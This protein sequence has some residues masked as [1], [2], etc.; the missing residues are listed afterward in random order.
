MSCGA[1]L[2]TELRPD[3]RRPVTVLF[4]DVAG[5]TVL[6]ERFEPET[7]RRIMSRYFATVGEACE[8]H[9]GTVEK[10]IGDAAMVVFG[11]PVAQEDHALRAVRAAAELGTALSR[12]NG[13]LDREW[14]VRI[15]TRTGINSGEVVAGDPASGQALVTGEAV[16]VAA[17]L[18]QAAE[19]G[20]VLIG[21]ATH[22]LVSAVIRAEPA[23]PVHINGR[24]EPVETFRLVEVVSTA[25]QPA[26]RL[27]VRMLGRDRELTLLSEEFER[28]LAK[29]SARRAVVLGPAGIG[30]S[31]LAQEL[32]ATIGEQASVFSGSCLPYGEGI[33]FWPLAEIVRQAAGEHPETEIARLLVGDP[34]AESIAEEVMQAVG[35]SEGGGS[36]RDASWAVRRFLEALARERPV[37]LVID[38]V[39]WAE[40]PLLDLI[41]YLTER[42][43]APL[44]LVCLAREELTE[45]RPAWVGGE[46]E[47]GAIVLQPLP[48]AE[49]RTLVDDLVAQDAIDDS[50]RS[51]LVDR[52]DGNPLFAEQMLAFVREGDG[53]EQVAIPPTIHAL[54]AARLDRLPVAELEV[55]GAASVIGREFW[56]DAVSALVGA[57]DGVHGR[58]SSLTSREL[59]ASGASTLTGDEGFAFRHALIRDAAYEALTKRK[60][61]A[62][63]ERFANWLEDRYGERLVELEAILGYHL[64]QAYRYH[65]E[66]APIDESARALARRGAARL[67]SAGRRAARARQD[68]AAV[69]LLERGSALLPETDP[70]RLELLP[71]IGESL[72]GTANHERAGEI[73]EQ[74]LELARQAGNSAVEGNSRLGRAHIWFVAEPERSPDEIVHEAEQAIEILEQVGDG[75]GLGEAWRLIGEMR[76]Y[77]GQAAAGQSALERALEYLGPEVSPRSWNAILFA[78]GMCLLD[79]P[80]HLDRAVEFARERL[81]VAR[82]EGIPSLEA[83]ML[84]LLGIG[85]T[86]LGQFAPARESLAASTEISDELGLTYMAQW[87]KRSLGHLELAAGNPLAAEQAVRSSYEVLDEMGLKGSLGEAAIPL[88]DALRLQGRVDEAEGFLD[89]VKE[90]WASNDASI[91]APR[92]AVRAKLLAAR[93]WHVHAERAAAR[94][95]R[96]VRRTDWSCLQADA[97]IAHAEVLELAGREAETVPVLR[98][99][100]RVAGEKGYAVVAAAAA[101]GL[102]RLGEEAADQVR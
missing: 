9:G 53:R 32:R 17:R 52:A 2:G 5:S 92:L 54:L 16:N 23:A 45:Q 27:D 87:S 47:A 65:A 90:D 84:H 78:L 76:T 10:F 18:E 67:A 31:R 77:A 91:E 86:R 13:E 36:G 81:T 12:L 62:L 50:V 49:M 37:A 6:A 3:S 63:H 83:D 11:I 25:G 58:L 101:E 46:S 60:R 33:T 79:G 8:R 42:V 99:A 14:G 19:P 26:R 24:D 59:V 1:R 55:I 43:D 56:A 93:G 4:N 44:M 7:L 72:E 68:G 66:L 38:D 20:D 95:L 73:Y 29:R 94:A 74:A 96:L 28:V 64:E 82:E 61:G 22:R 102:E 15:E 88:A 48:E 70:E 40:P 30:K 75:R 97:L 57:P 80:T 71:A 21:E 85:E 98:E 41:E 34:H 100:A 35:L 89:V 39:H 69:N 51:E